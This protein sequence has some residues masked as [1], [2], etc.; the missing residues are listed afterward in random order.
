VEWRWK[1]TAFTTFNDCAAETAPNTPAR[2]S[3]TPAIFWRFGG[4]CFP[5]FARRAIV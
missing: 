5:D 4:D 1:I 3:P 2:G